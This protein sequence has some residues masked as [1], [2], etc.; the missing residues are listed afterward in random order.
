WRWG[1]LEQ[2]EKCCHE[3]LVI[4]RELDDRHKIARMLNVLGILN[5]L[6]ENND[7]AEKYY[8]QSLK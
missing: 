8:E 3:S 6:Q 4:Y 5:T 2:A 1:D 7:Q